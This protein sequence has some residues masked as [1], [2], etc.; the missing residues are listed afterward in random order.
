MRRSIDADPDFLL[1]GA[2][3]KGSKSKIDSSSIQQLVA[4]LLHKSGTRRADFM[5]EPQM[6]ETVPRHQRKQKDLVI[7]V[8]KPDN[9][10][11]VR[12]CCIA[13]EL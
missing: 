11:L 3:Q 1:F 8:V 12:H 9:G 5:Y 2:L 7:M 4:M 6:R 13:F 10:K